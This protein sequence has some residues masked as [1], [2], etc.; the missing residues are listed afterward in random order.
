MMGFKDIFKNT[1]FHLYSE[2][3]KFLT[4]LAYHSACNSLSALVVI[5]HLPVLP[6]KCFL[7]ENNVSR[8]KFNCVI[9]STD[10]G[11][12]TKILSLTRHQHSL[13]ILEK[14][15]SRQR[16]W[17]ELPDL[18]LTGQAARPKTLNVP[19]EARLGCTHI[20]TQDLGS[21]NAFIETW[22]A[23][24]QIRVLKKASSVSG[25]PLLQ[26]RLSG[27]NETASS[28]FLIKKII[29]TVAI[30]VCILNSIFLETVLQHVLC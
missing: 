14:Q 20:L 4:S 3:C 30:Y 29:L 2:T 22:E 24:N 26:Y 12:C 15:C 18:G 23:R 17:E 8:Y 9:S 10:M 1:C 11:I 16:G 6:R 19:C 21:Q 25:F 7:E 5:L 13:R 27:E 28:L